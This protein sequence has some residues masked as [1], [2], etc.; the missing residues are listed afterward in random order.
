MIEVK[1]PGYRITLK[2]I[3]DAD[4]EKH[5]IVYTDQSVYK[6]SSCVNIQVSGN[7]L[8]HNVCIAAGNGAT[9]LHKQSFIIEDNQ[10]IVCCSNSIFCLELPSL[11]FL[12]RT[13]ADSFTCFGLYKQNDIY[14]VHGELE[15]SCLDKNG[16]ILWQKGGND[17]FTTMEGNDNDFYITNTYIFATDWN[18]NIYT[19]DFNGNVISFTP[20]P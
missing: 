16:K 5:D 18:Y 9:T 20:A 12:W 1:N 4:L 6:F 2:N 17:I 14:I 10:L 8:Q 3:N 11:S 15:I 13:T 7:S 19:F